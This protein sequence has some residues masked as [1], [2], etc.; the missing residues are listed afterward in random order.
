MIK[1]IKM[2]LTIVLVVLLAF[3]VTGCGP[4]KKKFTRKKK[5]AAPPPVYFELEKY[6]K[7]PNAVLYRR[8]YIYWK[9]WQEELINKIAQGYKKDMRCS[10]E[11]ISNLRD[12]KR[13]LVEEKADELQAYIEQMQEI[14]E[15][16]DERYITIAIKKRAKHKLE[17]MYRAIK[18][19]FSFKSVKDYILADSIPSE[20]TQPVSA[21]QPASVTQATENIK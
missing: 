7:E 18:R 14:K 15:T 11:I 17:R 1:K 3:E 9:T 19:E 10:L 4:L 5:E 6:S 16:L 12:M 8:H 2:L 13:L 20:V 21:A